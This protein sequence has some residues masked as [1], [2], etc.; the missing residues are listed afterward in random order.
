MV[1][2]AR[3]AEFLFSFGDTVERRSFARTLSP[4]VVEEPLTLLLYSSTDT[5]TSSS[6]VQLSCCRCWNRSS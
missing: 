3:A 2:A 6:S 4:A 1:S 5:K